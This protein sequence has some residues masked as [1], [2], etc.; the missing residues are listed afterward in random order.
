MRMAQMLADFTLA[1]ADVLR[2]AVGKKDEELLRKETGKFVERAV[3]NGVDEG[4]AQEIADQVVTFGR[5]GFNRSHS[6]AYALLSYQTAWLKCHYPAEFMAALLSSV[7]DKT[8][9]VV[10]YIAE[11]REI[12]R[13]VPNRPNGIRV[14]PPDINESGWKFTRG[15][16][17]PDPLRTGRAAR[18][19]RRRGRVDPRVAAQGWPVQVAVRPGGPGRPAPGR[20]AGAGGDDSGRRPATRS[21]TARSCW[22]GSTSRSAK[23][24]CDTRS[25][26]PARLRFSTCSRPRPRK[27]PSGRNRRCRRCR[28]GRK[29]TG[30]HA[31]R[32][33]S[34]SSSADTRS[35][36]TRDVMRV[37]ERRQYVDAEAVPRPEDRARVRGH[38]RHAADVEEERVRSGHGSRSRTS[39]APRPFSPLARPGK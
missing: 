39:T 24:S 22:R 15:R 19:R 34:V 17:R 20:Q 37:L 35:R 26:S 27:R 1:E 8:D 9:D 6:V 7:V 28:A 30:W 36:N 21:A 31:K 11:C 3:A 32:R 12:A 23:R 29:R 18:R 4:M 33:F 2:K 14:L 13:T 25:A 5:Y 16:R 38:G 10:H